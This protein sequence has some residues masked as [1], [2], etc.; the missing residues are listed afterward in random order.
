MN[1]KKSFSISYA[2]YRA[3]VLLLW[4]QNIFSRIIRIAGLV[5]MLSSGF[6][7]FDNI[8]VGSLENYPLYLNLV[9]LLLALVLAD[10]RLLPY[11]IAHI[12][13]NKQKTYLT[14]IEL[15]IDE[16]RISASRP[17]EQSECSLKSYSDVHYDNEILLLM[18]SPL[19]M[20]ILPRRIFEDKEWEWL[21]RIVLAVK[22]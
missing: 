8:F 17:N 7:V 4:K 11:L 22:K 5:G 6:L 13:Y 12:R 9:M 18:K 16:K 21:L 20:T 10:G 3:A 15:S 2:D 1:I 19:L 14:N